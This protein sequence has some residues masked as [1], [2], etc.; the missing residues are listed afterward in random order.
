[1][2]L[3]AAERST[4][5]G[6]GSSPPGGPTAGDPSST[7]DRSSATDAPEAT[8]SAEAVVGGGTAHVAVAGT[9]PGTTGSLALTGTDPSALLPVAGG[10]LTGLVLAALTLS[11]H[12]QV[13]HVYALAFV[14]GLVTVVDNPARQTF[15]SEMVGPAQ[16]RNA[17]SLN[18]ASF[19][20]ARMVGPAL[21]GVLTA[22][23]GASTVFLLSGL[24]F[25]ATVTVLLTLD[26]A[27]LH[28]PSRETRRGP[29]RGVMGGFR[30]LRT[31]PDIL[32]VLSILFVVSTFGINFNIYTA[33]MARM[34]ATLPSPATL[35]SGGVAERPNA[36]AL[37]ARDG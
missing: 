35:I 21:A 29:G 6:T 24:A 22:A 26:G 11:G 10:L 8:D 12:V 34:V 15:V 16:I 36:L 27:S 19:N 25:A 1:M 4:T 28:S 31:R 17:V 13:A 30:Y 14:L 9:A 7:P 23:L 18:S 20:S 33:T 32:V 37:K 3:T 2:P 5:S